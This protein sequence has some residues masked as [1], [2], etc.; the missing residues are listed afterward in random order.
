MSTWYT[1]LGWIDIV[2][3]EEEILLGGSAD[4]REVMSEV[5]SW[6]KTEEK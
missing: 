4:C 3:S 2:L 1:S 6:V 5:S